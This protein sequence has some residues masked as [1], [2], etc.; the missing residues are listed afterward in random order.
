MGFSP[1][2]PK[3]RM[4]LGLLHLQLFYALSLRR[5]F[6]VI[7]FHIDGK[8]NAADHSRAAGELPRQQRFVEQQYAEN[9][10]EQ[11]LC[12][13]E[14]G[15]GRRREHLLRR[16]LDEKG[17]RC[18]EQGRIGER[19]PYR[20]RELGKPGQRIHEQGRDQIINS[21]KADLHRGEQRRVIAR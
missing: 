17:E 12:G 5:G 20:S 3:T 15:S 13:K 1:D 2:F 11:A 7:V 18:G 21:G 14:H 10:A 16:G 4:A 9:H 19:A 6:G 8:Q